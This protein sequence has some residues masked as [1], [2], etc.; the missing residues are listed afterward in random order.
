MRRHLT[1]LRN[2]NERIR[3]QRQNFTGVLPREP[4]PNVPQEEVILQDSRDNVFRLSTATN[5]HLLGLHDAGISH[6]GDQIYQQA[7]TNGLWL[8][9][10]RDWHYL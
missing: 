8:G 3:R 7:S 9:P 5:R 2:E 4:D 1:R 6:L 10:I